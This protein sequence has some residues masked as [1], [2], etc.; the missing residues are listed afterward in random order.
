VQQ[1]TSAQSIVPSQSSS[2]LFLHENSFGCWVPQSAGQRHVYPPHE[3]FPQHPIPFQ[4]RNRR[5]RR[6]GLAGWRCRQ[7]LQASGH[8][9]DREGRG[10]PDERP[11]R[12]RGGRRDVGIEALVVE[13]PH[14]RAFAFCSARRSGTP[15]SLHRGDVESSRCR[16]RARRCG[17]RRRGITLLMLVEGNRNAEIPDAVRVHCRRRTRSRGSRRGS[18]RAEDDASAFPDHARV[19]EDDGGVA[20]ATPRSRTSCAASCRSAKGS[21]A[22][23]SC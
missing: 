16:R 12:H 23:W 20:L 13:R 10:P 5:G 3:P 22:D 8:R 6:A 1:S 4:P 19:R 15:K 21:T 14:R 11:P 9:R 7:L 18:H 2:M 17:S